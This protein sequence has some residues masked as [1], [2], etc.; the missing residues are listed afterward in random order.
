MSLLADLAGTA[1]NFLRKPNASQLQ[2]CIGAVGI[3]GVAGSLAKYP[4]CQ[5]YAGQMGGTMAMPMSPLMPPL[6]QQSVTQAAMPISYQPAMTIL[7]KLVAPAAGALAT[8]PWTTGGSLIAKGLPVLN[9]SLALASGYII[10]GSMVYDTAGKLIGKVR[11]R[12]RMNPLN[13][14]AAKRAAR[15]LCAVQ[16]L[17]GQITKAIPARAPRA[18]RRAS[19]FRRKKR[20]A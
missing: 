18:R 11:K 13:Y 20:C 4:Q 19:P 14:R 10:A 15:R 12:R 2:D 6:Q 5:P 7:P 9:R 17:C 3:Y 8:V 16:D 1:L